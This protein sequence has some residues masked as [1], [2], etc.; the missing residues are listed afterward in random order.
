MDSIISDNLSTFSAH[1]TNII[2]ILKKAGP[3]SLIVMDELGS[4][5]DPA[6]GMGIAMAVLDE[7]RKAGPCSLGDN[8][9]R[10]VKEYANRHAN[11]LNARM[12][13]DRKA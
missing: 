1:I 9:F 3:E 7:L 4:G 5:T 13:F 10:E 11:I 8:P 2:D 6:E 12:E